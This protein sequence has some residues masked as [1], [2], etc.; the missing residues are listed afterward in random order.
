MIAS[1]TE[2]TRK[3][4]KVESLAESNTIFKILV[5]QALGTIRI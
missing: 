1:L 2:H 5:L 3:C 4:L